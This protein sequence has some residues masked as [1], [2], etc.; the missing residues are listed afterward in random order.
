MRKFAT[1][2]F[3][4]LA[5]VALV[6]GGNPVQTRASSHREAPNISRDPQADNTDVYAFVSND[7]RDSVTLIANFN[8]L[9]DPGGGPNY[10]RFGDDVLYELN[11]DNDGDAK[12]DITFQFR[13][14]TEV[15]N[16][17]T[18]L[19][20]TGPVRSIDDPNLN[21]RQFYS[22]AVLG[23][24]GND[25]PV[26]SGTVIADNLPVAPYYVGPNSYPDGYEQV[27]MQAVRDIGN[28]IKVFAGPRDDPFF[29]DVG[30]TFDLL[31]G[32]RGKDGL[33]GLNVH[34]IAIQ[35]PIV[36]LQGPKDSI[37]GVHSTTH[38]RTMSVM[39]AMGGSKASAR[40]SIKA[41]EPVV[42][43]SRLG[44]PLVNEVVMPL[45]LKDA[46][47]SLK[48]SQDA[49][50]FTSETPAGGL[51]RK[52]I[53]DPELARLLHGIMGVDVPAPPR[54]DIVTIFLTGIPKLNQPASVTPAEELRLNMAIPPSDNPNR[55]G[56]LGGDMAGFPNGRRPT[57]DVTDIEL[58]A[59]AGATPL[60]PGFEKNNKLGDG[61]NGN[62]KPFKNTFPYL[63]E[64]HTYQEK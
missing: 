36:G 56:L 5:M 49:V 26:R 43:V 21:I 62:D 9:E 16:P 4:M 32:I 42:Q 64:P 39:R 31:K 1:A 24:G 53:L 51:F 19:Y 63:A 2:G 20:N 48:T 60:T 11:I 37:I 17:G 57:D 55:M 44:M 38:R 46:F 23:K 45:A 35:V 6:L 61:V 13:F 12:D 14:R 41:K 10:Y 59:V 40:V 27:A 52:S 47:N 22:V 8:P 15:R 18:F 50:L 33:S 25:D 7:R 3:I 30:G 58:Q 28:G 29:I 54:N 34:T